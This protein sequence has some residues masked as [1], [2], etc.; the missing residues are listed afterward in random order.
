MHE[1]APPRNTCRVAISDRKA[2]ITIALK[3][4][5]LVHSVSIDYKKAETLDSKTKHK[6]KTPTQKNIKKTPGQIAK[7][8]SSIFLWGL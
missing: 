7:D 8:L 3:L 6:Q 2:G 5:S 4:I 1:H